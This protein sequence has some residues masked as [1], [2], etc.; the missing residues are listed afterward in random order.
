M[1]DDEFE[2]LLEDMP[3]AMQARVRYVRAI[4]VISMKTKRLARNTN[5][6]GLI[7]GMKML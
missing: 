7:R 2:E 3:Y 4:A 6:R 5:Y 1:S